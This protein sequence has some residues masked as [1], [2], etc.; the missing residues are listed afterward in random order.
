MEPK[1]KAIKSYWRN[2]PILAASQENAATVIYTIFHHHL[3]NQWMPTFPFLDRRC[4]EFHA[5]QYKH[6]TIG[7]SRGIL[8]SNVCSS[9]QIIKL[10]GR[11]QTC[12]QSQWLLGW[13]QLYLKMKSG[14]AQIVFSILHRPGQLKPTSPLQKQNFLSPFSVKQSQAPFL[15]PFHL[16]LLATVLAQSWTTL[17]GAVVHP[18]EA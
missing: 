13:N 18:E 5:C 15:L 12:N 7:Q 16:S 8:G 9:W 1:Q 6:Q 10:S 4:A 3:L 17:V 14:S 11:H 2:K